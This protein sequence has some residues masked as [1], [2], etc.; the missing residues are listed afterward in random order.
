[1]IC[2]RKDKEKYLREQS[3]AILER[4]GHF[5]DKLYL[6]FGGKLICDYHAARVLPGFDPDAKI[7]RLAFCQIAAKAKN[8]TAQPASNPFKDT[9]DTA[10][11]ALNNVGV[12]NGMSADTF[13]PNDLLTRAQISKIIW[14]LRKG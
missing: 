13:A 1:M 3:E 8:L 7:T 4:A 5:G 10:V 6:E 2:H 11:L 12:I 9:T 14:T